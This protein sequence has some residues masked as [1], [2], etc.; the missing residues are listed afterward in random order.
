V[1]R[2]R[3]TTNRLSTERGDDWRKSSVCRDVDPELFWPVGTTG[4]ALAQAERAKAVCRRCPDWVQTEC[5]NFAIEQ[6][7]DDG[8][9]AAM[10]AAERRA[11]EL[12]RS[13][14]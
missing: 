1:S 9:F 6:G 4:P 8:I 2:L 14:A 10:D 13:T 5:L 7:I 12:N 11:Y 3:F